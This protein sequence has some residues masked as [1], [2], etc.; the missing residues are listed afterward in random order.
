MFISK[1]STRLLLAAITFAALVST[2][3]LAAF[4]WDTGNKGEEVAP[5][6][7]KPSPRPP[8]AGY[9]VTKSEP[10]VV[11]APAREF[12]TAHSS[13]TPVAQAPLAHLPDYPTFKDGL[14]PLTQL[15]GRY[16]A[17]GAKGDPDTDP[18]VWP[19]P[20]PKPTPTPTP[21]PS[22]QGQG[23]GDRGVRGFSQAL[24]PQVPGDEEIGNISYTWYD[25]DRVMTVQLQPGL[26]ARQ[27]G[28]GFGQDEVIARVGDDSIVPK[29]DKQ[30]ADA[31]PVFRS[32]SD[33]SL[34]TLPGGVLLALDS[35]WTQEQIDAF[36]MANDID[37]ADVSPI[38]YLGNTFFIETKPGLP[39]LEEANKLALLDGVEISSPNW[40]QERDR[41]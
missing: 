25:G 9:S 20:T 7:E 17:A 29:S 16:L 33:G 5:L 26:E 10:P 22:A 27:V 2:I 3:T 41:R 15:P 14:S 4:W 1:I 35:S 31:K 36:F 21:T 12:T 37:P 28:A 39:S 11:P 24:D 38:E 18:E 6:S 32:G 30:S 19:K 23:Q 13:A 8:L 34:M 40:W